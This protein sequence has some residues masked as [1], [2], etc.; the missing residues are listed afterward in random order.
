MDQCWLKYGWSNSDTFYFMFSTVFCPLQP[1]RVAGLL[2]SST[3]LQCSS[4]QC[5]KLFGHTSD[6][7]WNQKERLVKHTD[8][9]NSEANKS[10]I[11]PFSTINLSIYQRLCHRLNDIRSRRQILSAVVINVNPVSNLMARQKLLG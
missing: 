6:W 7:L 1:A 9:L 2:F 10:V 3:A 11:S 5:D 4:M 8:L